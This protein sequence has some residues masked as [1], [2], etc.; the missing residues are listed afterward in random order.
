MNEDRSCHKCIHYTVCGYKDK[1]TDAALDL[2]NT[3]RCNLT[4]AFVQTTQLAASVCPQYV[5]DKN[6]VTTKQEKEND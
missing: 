4:D 6:M 1:A 3:T 2:L 5:L